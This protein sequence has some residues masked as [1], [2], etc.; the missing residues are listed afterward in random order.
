MPNSAIAG[1]YNNC[2][3]SVLRNCQFFFPRLGVP[4]YI[5]TSSEGEI[6][7]FPQSLPVFSIIT[8]FTLAILFVIFCCGFDL[9]FP[10]A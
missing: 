5:L 9:H 8:I 3:F 4:F 10:T 2:V 1:S 6:L 7:F